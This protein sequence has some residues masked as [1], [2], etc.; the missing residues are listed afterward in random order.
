LLG[1]GHG[2][3]HFLLLLLFVVDCA[4]VKADCRTNW[5]QIEKN[6]NRK[7]KKISRVSLKSEEGKNW[8][9]RV[10]AVCDFFFLSSSSSSRAHVF[11][12]SAQLLEE[13]GN[14]LVR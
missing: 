5:P 2:K 13:I 12:F 8:I 4:A 3:K 14:I 7:F 6:T 10:S 11:L 9:W 1:L